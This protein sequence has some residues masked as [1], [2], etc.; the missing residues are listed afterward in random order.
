M[1]DAC[2]AKKRVIQHLTNKCIHCSER[3]DQFVCLFQ[4]S[5][6]SMELEPEVNRFSLA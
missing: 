4:V 2:D 3:E 1:I 5:A 6:L